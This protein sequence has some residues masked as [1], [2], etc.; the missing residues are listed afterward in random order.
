MKFF[1]V[2]ISPKHSTQQVNPSSLN[3]QRAKGLANLQTHP[4]YERPLSADN[5]WEGNLS[6]RLVIL[7]QIGGSVGGWRQIDVTLT[8]FSQYM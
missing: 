7:T 6:S 1:S 2:Q 4:T 8:F 3:L 5:P